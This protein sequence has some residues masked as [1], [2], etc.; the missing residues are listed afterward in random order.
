MWS[1]VCVCV[2]VCLSVCACVCVCVR[3]CV[4]ARAWVADACARFFVHRWTGHGLEVASLKVTWE[5][6]PDSDA[7]CTPATGGGNGSG[8]DCPASVAQ[9]Y[10]DVGSCRIAGTNAAVVKNGAAA[11]RVTLEGRSC[12]KSTVA[13]LVYTEAGTTISAGGK[14]C[15]ITGMPRDFTANDL[16][17]CGA[18]PDP[19]TGYIVANVEVT[20]P[21]L[22]PNASPRFVG[23]TF[24]YGPSA[25]TDYNR[26]STDDKKKRVAEIPLSMQVCTTID[27][28]CVSTFKPWQQ[29]FLRLRAASTGGE[30]IA[31]KPDFQCSVQ[32][33]TSTDSAV[34]LMNAERASDADGHGEWGKGITVPFWCEPQPA[35]GLQLLTRVGVNMLA[36]CGLPSPRACVSSPGR[37]QLC[38]IRCTITS[39]FFH[40]PARRLPDHAQ[41]QGTRHISAT[42]IAESNTFHL[43][44]LRAPNGIGG[45]EGGSFA[46]SPCSNVAVTLNIV[47][48]AVTALTTLVLVAVVAGAVALCYHR[49]GNGNKASTAMHEL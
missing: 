3:V 7:G 41:D 20:S 23:A 46:V 36:S 12:T 34:P 42:G 29:V 44:K 21:C 37:D 17:A 43:E 25:T 9:A 1:C 30:V 11:W 24:V 2:C 14:G 18:T 47:V 19:S 48:V 32:S 31:R 16:F 5:C 38:F 4:C 35:L 15:E 13:K 26:A 49:R 8:N 27:G 28:A 45:S 39:L 40:T 33:S 10:A 22:P 6:D